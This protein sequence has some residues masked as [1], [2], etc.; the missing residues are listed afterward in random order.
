M[1][2][3]FRNEYISMIGDKIQCQALCEESTRNAGIDGLRCVGSD[4]QDYTPQEAQQ[5]H[6]LEFHIKNSDIAVLDHHSW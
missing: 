2:N 1:P 6:G 5:P 4:K 3:L